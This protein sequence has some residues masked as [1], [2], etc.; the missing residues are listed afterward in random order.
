VLP[1]PH[2]GR[3]VVGVDGDV[4]GPRALNR[5]TLERQLLLRREAL[6][7]AEAVERLVG[8]QA[9][10][11]L[12]PYVGLWTRLRG[13]EA[14][15]LSALL[16]SRR[17]VRGSFMRATVHL[18][19]ARDCLAVRPVV[20]PVLERGFLAQ[21]RRQVAGLDLAAVV[22][23]GRALLAERPRTRAELAALL[24]PRWPEVDPILLAYVVSYFA[25]LVQVPPRG[26]WGST[27]PATWTTVE[28]WL[29]SPLGTD[30]TPDRLVL[31]YL[32]AFGPASV[33]DVATWSGLTG[34]RE[35]VD[36]L[37]PRLRAFRSPDGVELVDLP[38]GPRPH[39]DVPAPPRFL[40][41]YDNL[42]LSHADRSRVNPSGRRVPLPPGNGA[43]VGTLLVD[44]RWCATW[45]TERSPGAATLVVEPFVRLSGPD[46]DAV[47]EEGAALLAFTAPGAAH[48]VRIRPTR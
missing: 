23:A 2:S 35:V 7:A 16:G 37:R 33:A 27:G 19:T 40:P 22:A 48:D 32:G 47:A 17:A 26:V 30:R 39:P 34:L 9:Q 8:L 43:A 28:S 6:P 31:R 36:R 10:A 44:G 4:L 14:A 29:D 5:A 11:P 45:R 21:F 42:L 12:A 1:P 18:M 20:Q 15:E 38:D 24:A 3:T 46:A 41:E 13:F 25:A